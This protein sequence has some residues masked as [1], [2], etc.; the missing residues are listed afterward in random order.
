MKN[1]KV[2]SRSVKVIFGAMTLGL[3]FG[4]NPVTAAERDCDG[5]VVN[6][7]AKMTH[8]LI[9]ELSKSEGNF[10]DIYI[11]MWPSASPEI[12]IKWNQKIF[13]DYQIFETPD[14][15]H[16]RNPGSPFSNEY[17]LLWATR[18]TILALNQECY[19]KELGQSYALAGSVHSDE[20]A[21][22]P[23][24]ASRL[25]FNVN[26]RRL[27]VPMIPYRPGFTPTYSR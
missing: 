8:G 24:G 18:S 5:F 6:D 9:E 22:L 20:G 26:G 21:S 14:T 12:S 25:I 17:N 4:M 7:T 11:Q 16:R 2:I 23:S 13:T 27:N 15:L 1:G 19:I 10:I 3:F